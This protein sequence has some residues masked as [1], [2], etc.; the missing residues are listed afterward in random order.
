MSKKKKRKAKLRPE[1]PSVAAPAGDKPAE[2]KLD[3]FAVAARRAAIEAAAWDLYIAEG[4]DAIEQAI[5]NG[6]L[7]AEAYASQMRAARDGSKEWGPNITPYEDRMNRGLQLRLIKERNQW[8]QDCR[9]RIEAEY[10]DE[11]LPKHENPQEC[12]AVGSKQPEPDHSYTSTNDAPAPQPEGEVQA[13]TTA[14]SP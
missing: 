5:R 10:P 6:E 9:E 11:L 2:T 4:G 12:A 8:L 14:A 3:P 13:A 1:K 7:T